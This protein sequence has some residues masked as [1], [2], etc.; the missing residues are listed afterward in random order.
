[1]EHPINLAGRR[2]GLSIPDDDVER[3][4]PRVVPPATGPGQRVR[5]SAR[6]Q[7]SLRLV[8]RQ[9]VLLDLKSLGETLLLPPPQSASS[10]Q[11]RV[12]SRRR[13]ADNGQNQPWRLLLFYL[14]VDYPFRQLESRELGGNFVLRSRITRERERERDLLI[15]FNF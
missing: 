12:R 9:N 2:P 11:P 3:R 6:R 8:S 10:L 1:M 14:T 15:G 13:I 7:V 4:N 5:K